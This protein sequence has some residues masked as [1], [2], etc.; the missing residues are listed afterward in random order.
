MG[1][2]VLPAS[3]DPF[4]QHIDQMIADGRTERNAG[5]AATCPK[6][7]RVYLMRQNVDPDLV[8]ALQPVKPAEPRACP[9]DIDNMRAMRSVR[10]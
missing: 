2:R 1:G 4:A 8:T 10:G 7:D 5:I 9:A 6:D 3:V